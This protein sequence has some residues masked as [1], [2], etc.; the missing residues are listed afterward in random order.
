MFTATQLN[1]F[2][3]EAK[4]ISQ[5]PFMLVDKTILKNQAMLFRELFPKI[6]IQYAFKCFPDPQVVASLDTLIQGYDVASVGEIKTLLAQGVDVSRLSYSN[7]VKAASSIKIANNLGVSRFAF[8][9]EAELQKIA[10]NAPGSSVYFRMDVHSAEGS[11]DFS[12]KFGSAPEQALPLL[13]HAQELGLRP[14]G[15]TF[16]VGSQAQDVEA[17]KV[18]IAQ[19]HQIMNEAK[20]Q[21]LQLPELNIGGGFPVE[22]KEDSLAITDLAAAVNSEVD[23]LIADFPEVRLIAEPGRFLTADCGAIVATVIGKEVRGGT[24]WL[25]LDTGTFQS[26]IELFEFDE[27]IYPVISQKHLG[28][29]TTATEAYALTGPTC[30]SYDTMTRSIQLPAGIEVGDKLF[31][32]MT[33]AYTLAYGSNFNGFEIPEIVFFESESAESELF[34]T[35]EAT[36]AVT[37]EAV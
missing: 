37:A 5:S 24:P 4:T 25:Y 6:D 21:G 9:S 18:A 16:H 17:W 1:R 7:P 12:S 30:D 10:A 11:L 31:I 26:F 34:V 2:A 35:S 23:K 36:Q 14:L 8:Q 28:D 33:G 27:F 15:V 3:A 19:A 22:Y 32:T 29:T 20:T 13:T